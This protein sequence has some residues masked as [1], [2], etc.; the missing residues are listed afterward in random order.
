MMFGKFVFA[1]VI[2]LMSHSAQAQ[3]GA[4]GPNDAGPL[5]PD[6]GSRLVAVSDIKKAKTEC[7]RQMLDEMIQPYTQTG[8]LGP[9]TLT[10][11]I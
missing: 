2:V 6:S 9:W 11:F 5:I 8:V 1:I 10:Y 4:N 3:R 7:N